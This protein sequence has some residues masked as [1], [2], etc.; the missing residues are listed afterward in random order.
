LFDVIGDLIRVFAVDCVGRVR[1][2]SYLPGMKC[3]FADCS[4][5]SGVVHPRPSSE[6]GKY[7]QVEV[8]EL[9]LGHLLRAGE[10]E[11]VTLHAGLNHLRL[12]HVLNRCAVGGPAVEV[13]PPALR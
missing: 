10:F 6:D 13:V 5:R 9:L 1:V 11:S 12:R 4:G 3:A 8:A 7:R 2:D